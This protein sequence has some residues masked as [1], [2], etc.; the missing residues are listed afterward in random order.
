MDINSLGNEIYED[1]D[2]IFGDYITKYLKDLSSFIENRRG[3]SG[4]YFHVIAETKLTKL[5]SNANVLKHIYAAY[6]KATVNVN[7]YISKAV[8][9]ESK[10][11]MLLYEV[12]GL[13]SVNHDYKDH[14][15][16][17]LTCALDSLK[18][19]LT[20]NHCDLNNDFIN[21]PRHMSP[22]CFINA[23]KQLEVDPHEMEGVL[24]HHYM[25]EFMVDYS[26]LVRKF[27]SDLYLDLG[28]N[29]I[30]LVYEKM[31]N[32]VKCEIATFNVD[33]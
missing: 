33:A 12:D 27:W 4:L 19:K 25:N 3:V 31:T 30:P 21:K 17:P 23:C 20:C 18:Y 29:V 28:S 9:D 15:I 14:E 7:D 1:L 6:I 11:Q 16:F 5:A 2:K 10:Y 22:E 26:K 24:N 13:I 8:H 32:D